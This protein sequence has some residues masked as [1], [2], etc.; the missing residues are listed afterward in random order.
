MAAA[1]SADDHPIFGSSTSSRR[2]QG[3]SSRLPAASSPER[4][5]NPEGSRRAR[6]MPP[7]GASSPERRRQDVIA[8]ALPDPFSFDLSGSSGLS[9]TGIAIFQGV[10]T[11]VFNEQLKQLSGKADSAE[12]RQFRADLLAALRQNT[13]AQRS[14]ARALWACREELALTGE[15]ESA[16]RANLEVHMGSIAASL[17]AMLQLQ[18]A[19]AV[20]AADGE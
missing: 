11:N 15:A 12:L 9:A 18:T 1:G 5:P 3:S 17:D 14:S 8:R 20:P 2:H 7:A 10:V 19:A 4:N 6:S 16:A 13:A